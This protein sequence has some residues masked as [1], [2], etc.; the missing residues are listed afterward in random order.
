MIDM[1]AGNWEM[2][3]EELLALQSILQSSL[4]CFVDG[5]QRVI[6]DA[7]AEKLMQEGCRGRQL[8]CTAKIPPCMPDGGLIVQVR[9]CTFCQL[10]LKCWVMCFLLTF[11][12][13]L[14]PGE[15]LDRA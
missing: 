10:L 11:R 7:T 4:V 1:D 3:V 12:R 2:N 13:L 9:G 6:D 5:I 15:G 14:R 8:S